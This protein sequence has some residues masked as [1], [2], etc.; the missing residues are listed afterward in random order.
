MLNN[1][2]T[3][4]K[5]CCNSRD[6]EN[7]IMKRKTGNKKIGLSNKLLWV[8]AAAVGL[9]TYSFIKNERYTPKKKEKVTLNSES[10]AKL[11]I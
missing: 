3:P 2:G 4:P 10:K 1:R 7:T 8:G 6:L 9:A 5:I 11:F